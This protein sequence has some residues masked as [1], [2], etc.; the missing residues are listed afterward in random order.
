MRILNRRLRP[1]SLKLVAWQA[2]EALSARAHHPPE[3]GAFGYFHFIP[4]IV[5]S[6]ARTHEPIDLNLREKQRPGN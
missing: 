3:A 6:G 2:Y 4:T 1:P 5:E